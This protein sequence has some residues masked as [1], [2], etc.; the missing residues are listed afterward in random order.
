MKKYPMLAPGERSCKI[1]VW[2]IYYAQKGAMTSPKGHWLP[3]VPKEGDGRTSL[4]IN[5][6]S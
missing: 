5:S 1:G 3:L 4:G 6:P 2:K